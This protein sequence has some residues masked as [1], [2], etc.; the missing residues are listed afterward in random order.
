MEYKSYPQIKNAFL[1]CLIFLLL[2]V[3]F[4]VVFV[5]AGAI[6]K[7]IFDYTPD[8]T[9]TG[10]IKGMLLFPSIGL[11]ILIGYK[12]TKRPFAESFPLKKIPIKIWPSLVIFMTG[13]IILSAKLAYLVQTVFPAPDSMFK[14][15]EN[16]TGNQNIVIS[17]IIIAVI[18][19]IFE[20]MLFRGLFV[21]GFS[22]TYSLRTTIIMSAFLFSLIHLNPWQSIN[23]FFFGL[24]LAWMYI[25]TGSLLA[26]VFMHF[27]NNALAVIA[28][29]VE[30]LSPDTDYGEVV[31]PHLWFSLVGLTL[32]AIGLF[33]LL[34]TL[35][36]KEESL[37]TVIKARLAK[38]A[39][40]LPEGENM[41]ECSPEEELPHGA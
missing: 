9:L 28:G 41:A 29:Y 30:K 32:I 13:Y 11:A 6:I 15:F 7:S 21:T 39:D 23:T 18:P 26:P 22:R 1:L 37:F 5:L 35:P 27:F 31:L 3:G 34:K 20:E 36:P 40:I 10:I 14:T 16:L 19:G 25:R 2:Q 38:E 17:L 8:S 33:F 12:K 24:I 4:G